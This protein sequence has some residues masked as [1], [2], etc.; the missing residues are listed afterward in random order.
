MHQGEA[1]SGRMAT[2]TCAA[3]IGFGWEAAGFVRRVQA[4]AGFLR[5][6]HATEEGTGSI[7]VTGG[8]KTP[9]NKK[10]WHLKCQPF[11]PNRGDS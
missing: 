2:T 11:G 6:G 3:A 9:H 1:L 10:G 5:T 7:P 8:G 4:P